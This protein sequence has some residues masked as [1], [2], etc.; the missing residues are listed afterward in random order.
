MARRDAMMPTTALMPE[1]MML[2]SHSSLS[3]STKTRT[4]TMPPTVLM[5]ERMTPLSSSLS[6]PTMTRTGAAAKKEEDEAAA[7]RMTADKRQERTRGGGVSVT[8]GRRTRKKKRRWRQG[9][10]LRT[11][12]W[13]GSCG[14]H[15]HD[16]DCGDDDDDDHDGVN[17]RGFGCL[18]LPGRRDMR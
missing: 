15:H 17:G 12:R 11:E 18:R 9:R 7:R 5:L 3:L 1:R 16:D 14:Y 6:T 8:T 10:Q 4:G 2:S 13:R